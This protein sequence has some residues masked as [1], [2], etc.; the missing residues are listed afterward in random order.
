MVRCPHDHPR[1]PDLPVVIFP[2]NVGDDRALAEAYRRLRPD[3]TATAGRS[4]R[5]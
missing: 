5:A 2:G 3:A 4:R 1:Y